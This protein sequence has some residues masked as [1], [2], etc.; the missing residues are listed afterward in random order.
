MNA[1]PRQRAKAKGFAFRCV[2]V[3]VILGVVASACLLKLASIQLL[4]HSTAL[5]ATQQRTLKVVTN[6]KRGRILDANGTVLAQSL[7]RYNIIANPQAATEFTPIACNDKTKS[8]CHQIDGK[9]VGATGAAAVARLLAT[10][11]T[12]V[13]AMEL[14]AKISNPNS[15]YAVIAKDVTPEVKRKI[16]DLNLG[17][18]VYGELTNERVYSSGTLLGPVL[19]GVNADGEGVA[20]L[21]L[22]LNKKLNGTDGYEVYQRSNGGTQEIPGTLTESKA[23]VNGS[24]VT[25]TIDGTVDWYVKKALLDG[26]KKY[27]ASWAL[28]VVYDLKTGGVIALEDTDQYEAGSDDA[29]LNTSRVVSE[30]F[31]PGSIGKVFTMSG[32]LQEGVHKATDRFTVPDTLT[33]DGQTY[34]DA[35]NHADGRWTYAGILQHSSNVGMIL[36]ASNYSDQKRYEY[37]KK[38]GVGQL[39]GLGLS[40][41][42]EGLLYNYDQWDL[43]TR[44][45]VLFGQ[46]YTMNALQITRAIATVANGGVMPEFRIIDSTTDADGHVTKT[47][48]SNEAT[49]VIDESTAKQV[50]NAMESVSDLYSSFVSVPGYRVAAKSGTAEVVGS[51]GTLSSIISDWAGILPADNPRFVVTVVMKDAKVGSFGGVTAGP[52]FANIG[53]FLMQKYNVPA[54]AKRTDAIPVEW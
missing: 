5:A 28:G 1:T 34:K 32:E 29:K 31:D 4:G 50:L 15:Q 25:L 46:G 33:V 35:E 20:G 37:L 14:G 30:T 44:N 10:V 11:F 24:D 52:V 38:F 27:N 16:D 19:G 54:S 17:G 18:I 42:S 51:D 47:K 53:E 21:E 13:N 43:R 36:A 8:Y 45:T 7:E 48:S 2:I 49:R 26:I 6:A 41:E 12:D 9:P 23:A 3:A 22:M 40:G 39:S